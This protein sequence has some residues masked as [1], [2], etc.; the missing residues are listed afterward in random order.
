MDFLIYH[1]TPNYPELVFLLTLHTFY[2]T[3]I[4]QY[5]KCNQFLLIVQQPLAFF[6]NLSLLIFLKQLPVLIVY[7][8]E[9]VR[10]PGYEYL[11]LIRCKS[12]LLSDP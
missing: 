2:R 7:V 1:E 9:C 8:P 4:L 6:Q 12:M 3:Q 10:L 11:N 5:A